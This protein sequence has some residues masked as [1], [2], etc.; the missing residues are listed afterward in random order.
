MPEGRKIKRNKA[1]RYRVYPNAEQ[2]ILLKKS[3]GCRR[4]LYNQLLEKA[5]RD[6]AEGKKL[7]SM[8]DMCKYVRKE[9][10]PVH[11]WI[12]EADKFI[13]ED[14]AGS[15][16]K[17]Y[18][19]AFRKE[20][21]LPKY[22]SKRNA[23]QSYTT[24]YT[25]GNIEAGD[26]SVKIPK[27]GRI[28]AKIHRTAPE[29]WRIKNATVT[30]EG[31]G[32]YY[33]SVLYEYEEE[34]QE[35]KEIETAIGLD[36]KS[37]GLY[38]TSEGEKAEMPH[39]YRESQARLAKMQRRLSRKIEA[40][41][42][43]YAVKNGKRYPVYLRE[44]T[45]CRNIGKLKK[46]IAKLCEHIANQR[47]DYLHKRSHEFAE[48]YDAVIVEDLDMRE[49]VKEKHLAKA[50]LDNG[51]GMFRN[52]L[53]YKLEDRGKT[54]LKVDQYFPS[55]QMCSGCGEKN[56]VLKDLKIRKWRCPHCGTEHDRDIN[57]A[58]NILNEGMRMIAER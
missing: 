47:K 1:I 25:N 58:I 51:Y 13:V 12:E 56:P 28:R 31:S 11:P 54:F 39:R 5:E 48:A 34:E 46:K 44:L 42:D 22:K 18:E 49:I 53:E 35:P 29:S 20:A 27:V 3:F 52:F 45:E 23:K 32:K 57:A 10:K 19:K 30:L 17:G 6:H 15:L 41:I 38:V 21:E 43:H 50:T 55:S 2:E 16:R 26:R 24:Y 14:A 37:D 4:F 7:L 40:N 8:Y 9:V 33:I 36:Y